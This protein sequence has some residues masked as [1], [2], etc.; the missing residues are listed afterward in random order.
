MPDAAS[1]IK[2]AITHTSPKH[3]FAPNAPVDVAPPMPVGIL[4]LQRLVGNQVSRGVLERTVPTIQRDLKIDSYAWSYTG[5]PIF[6]LGFLWAKGA[7]DLHKKLK[8]AFEV[9]LPAA[10]KA[11][12]STGEEDLE[13]LA[14]TLRSLQKKYD[15]QPLAYKKTSGKLSG[16]ELDHELGPLLNDANTMPTLRKQKLVDDIRSSLGNVGSYMGSQLQAHR[17]EYD[18]IGTLVPKNSTG[19]IALPIPTLR[20]LATEASAFDS[21]MQIEIEKLQTAKLTQMTTP[22]P[23]AK[24]KVTARNENDDL[25][26]YLKQQKGWT[27]LESST[28]LTDP[29]DVK[30]KKEVCER[31]IGSQ[32]GALNQVLRS[33]QLTLES[34]HHFLFDHNIRSIGD[35]NVYL[36]TLG[37]ESVLLTTLQS[38]GLEGLT[39]LLKRGVPGALIAQHAGKDMVGVYTEY[40]ASIVTAP[41]AAR[42]YDPFEGV[43]PNTDP[44]D[45][46]TLEA[47]LQFHTLQMQP[48]G[49]GFTL[50]RTYN[51]TYDGERGIGG[52][53]LPNNTAGRWV[54]HV[55]RGPNG[56]LKVGSIKTWADRFL[57]G[58][59][60]KLTA[61][62]LTA[63]GIPAVDATRST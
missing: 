29:S 50:S 42:P 24:T 2:R 18:R 14:E 55:H 28:I 58:H 53:Y 51:S 63:A 4:R 7:E 1:R 62:K 19:S 34:V 10:I 3:R 57:L 54:V 13:K 61:D 16:E 22:S 37:D 21:K 32:V 52:E 43:N 15:N 45:Y 20:Q 60:Q 56:G 17:T 35:L 47:F 5:I 36:G 11:L 38:M 59:S 41:Q 8:Q 40:K 12:E 31:V 39:T 46:T 26:V 44:L 23:S 30:L 9:D 25:K 6:E 33:H 27:E 48:K 49:V